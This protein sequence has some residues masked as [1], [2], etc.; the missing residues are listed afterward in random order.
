MGGGFENVE[1][2]RKAR[3]S[4]AKGEIRE[5]KEGREEKS[6]TLSGKKKKSK[7]GIGGG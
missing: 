6:Q 3:T 7:G 4:Y 2:G 1:F 5:K